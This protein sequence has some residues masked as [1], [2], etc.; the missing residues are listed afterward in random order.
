[1]TVKRIHTD[2]PGLS[3]AAQLSKE[4]VFGL[5]KITDYKIMLF[6]IRKR[7]YPKTVRLFYYR[8]K[9]SDVS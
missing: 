3:K 6:E 8:E 4:F 5:C 9:T 2:Y 1:M 7:K